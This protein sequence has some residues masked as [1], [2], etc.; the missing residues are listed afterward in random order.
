VRGK[1]IVS[2]YFDDPQ[3]FVEAAISLD[4]KAKGVY[5]ILNIIAPALLARACNRLAYGAEKT[6]SDSDITRR[7][8]LLIDAD[9]RRPS[10]ISSTDAELQLAY[11]TAR[12]IIDYLTSLGFPAPGRGCSGN[13]AHILYAIDLDE[14]DGGLVT[15]FLKALAFK[16]NSARVA[17]DENL[18]PTHR[19]HH[20]IHEHNVRR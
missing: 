4:G 17:V 14:A 16:F 18:G 20:H 15:R 7:R 2:G 13:G 5:A 11:D 3:K 8:Y 6:T 1:G 19:R 10:D 12:A 9:P